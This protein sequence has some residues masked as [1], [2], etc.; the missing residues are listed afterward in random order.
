MAEPRRG[1]A[2]AALAALAGALATWS[3]GK[4]T[5]P[6]IDFGFELYVPW[7]LIEGEVLYRDIA[8]R[9]GPLS[10]YWNALLFGVFGVS[11]RTLVIANLAVLAAITALLFGLLERAL[12]RWGALAGC[13]VFLATCAFSQYGNVGNYNFVT[14]YQHGSTHGLLLGLALVARLARAQRL[15]HWATAGVLL[16]ALGLTKA[17]LFVPGLAVAACAA[18]LELYSGR[19]SALPAIAALAGASLLAPL[20]AWLALA[21]ALPADAALR[22]VLGNWPYL[23]G[24]GIFQDP[25]YARGAGLDAPAHQLAAMLGAA[26]ALTAAWLALAASERW[27]RA[28]PAAPG[29]IVPLGLVA[30]IGLGIAVDA[31]WAQLARVLPVVTGVAIALFLP[32]SLRGEARGR[33]GL[34]LAV[35]ALGLLGKLGLH[36]QIQHYGFALAAPALALGVAGAVARWHTAPARGIAV[37]LAAAFASALVADSHAIYQHKSFELASGRD[38]ILVASPE[39]S[40]RGRVLVRVLRDLE[41]Q[42]PESATLLALPEG[43]SLNYWLRRRN[44]TPYSLFLPTEQ[45]AQGG[46]EAM[47]DRMR[48]APP[49]Y[50]AL[51]HR[52]HREFGTGP[53]LDDPRN[54]GAFRSWLEREYTPIQL[55]GAEP[56]R[57]PAFGIAILRR[58]DGA[59]AAAAAE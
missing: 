3:W 45:V 58:T 38:A 5:D 47:L 39:T 57:G 27:A 28:R 25:F 19:S 22:G 9:N 29:W 56:F 23:V 37:G 44:S 2:L 35:F 4:W 26:A 33:S 34:L 20:V 54:G 32:A 21:T 50:V 30:G 53:F 6:L 31:P 36:P 46:A 49:D 42:L 17:E 41:A 55:V 15:T 13:A 12:S 7:R 43:A 10:P 11:L 18:A 48:A 14:P 52:G 1:A 16:G 24:A 40:P 59:A 51:V 8:Y